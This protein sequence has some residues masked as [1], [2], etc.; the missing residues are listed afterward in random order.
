MDHSQND[1]TEIKT[2]ELMVQSPL[3]NLFTKRWK[4]QG[5]HP[6][7][8]QTSRSPIVLLH[9]SLGCA[10]M[11]RD[12]PVRLCEATGRDVIAYDRLGFGQS[13]PYPGQLPN[14]FVEQ[15]AIESFAAVC[16][17]LMIKD[18]IALG[19]SVGGAMAIGIAA[20]LPKTCRAIITLAALSMIEPQTIDG[21]RRAKAFFSEP[22]QL[23]RLAQH[24]GDKA[25][26]VLSAWVDTWLAESF[27]EWNMDKL[28]LQVK[29][30]ALILHGDCDEYA[31]THHAER[32]GSLLTDHTKIDIMADTGHFPHRSHP[33]HVIAAIRSFLSTNRID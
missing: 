1:M 23:T 11:W 6:S 22:D 3:G 32:I 28:L 18:F 17:S 25:N 30:P 13:D 14:H 31:S 10:T 7:V 29:C 19:H 33:N 15:E 5:I 8:A 27:R 24:H 21:V 12:F 16:D 26:W 20:Q 9:E 2:I 4:A